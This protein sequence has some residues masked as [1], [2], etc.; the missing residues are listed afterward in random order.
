[1]IECLER[2]DTYELWI[3]PNTL[4]W[5]VLDHNGRDKKQFLES[6]ERSTGQNEENIAWSLSEIMG[7]SVLPSFDC[8]LSCLH[9][10]Y[11]NK[12][13]DVK[14]GWNDVVIS[15]FISFI[16]KLSVKNLTIGGG[17]PLM[18]SSC[19]KLIQILLERGI[20]LFLLTNGS[21][22]NKRLLELIVAYKNQIR[23]QV[24]FDASNAKDYL[25]IRGG[26]FNRLISNVNH[27]LDHDIDVDFSYTIS[28]LNEHDL[29]NFLML[30]KKMNPISLHFPILELMGR[31][32]I[33]SLK[34]PDSIKDI[35]LFLAYY[36]IFSNTKVTFVE[37]ILKSWA[38]K[39]KMH[40]CSAAC[41]QISFAP[42]G[43]IY[44]CSELF[45]NYLSIADLNKGVPELADIEKRILE[46][47]EIKGFGKNV[48]QSAC[49]DCAVRYFCAGSCRSEVMSNNTSFYNTRTTRLR[50]EIQKLLL[51]KTLWLF[52]IKSEAINARV[53]SV[54]PVSAVTFI[55]KAEA[56][57]C[58]S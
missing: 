52:L 48:A 47:Q 55:Q 7:V 16:D 10:F 2:I 19:E 3:N 6:I 50:C 42:D 43:K 13:T 49:P 51:L 11:G 41:R 36:G 31:A 5:I 17:E 54:L 33:N 12:D 44:P 28:S 9:C 1:M 35:Y 32:S 27:L 53:D 29:V 37:G 22:L 26:D 30:S 39:E 46:M 15:N 45:H 57:G 8:N 18:W 56:A 21:I 40:S 34:A 23:I 20:K 58:F 38:L 14:S 25:N 24:S 4:D